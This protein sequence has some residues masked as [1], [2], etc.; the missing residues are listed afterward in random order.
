MGGGGFHGGGGYHG[1]G[2]FRGGGGYRGGIG[3]GIGG[4]YRSGFRLGGYRGFPRYGYGY[5]YGGYASY[6]LGYYGGFLGGYYDSYLG[7]PYISIYPSYEYYPQPYYQPSGYYLG[8]PYAAPAAAPVIINQFSPGW[9]YQAHEPARLYEAPSSAAET[10]R[11]SGPP[12]Y[13]IARTD[14]TIVAALSY[15]VQNNSLHYTTLK[16]ESKRMPLSSVDRS[17][18]EQLN[19]ERQVEFKLPPVKK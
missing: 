17:L 13:L 9:D 16:H 12:I 19:S 5:G 18:S 6:G 14:D 3:V 8:S 2:G 15:E 4:G 7:S 1:G 10:R 11:P